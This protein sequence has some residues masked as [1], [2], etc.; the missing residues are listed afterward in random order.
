[1]SLNRVCGE[2]DPEPQD[3]AEVEARIALLERSQDTQAL[4]AARVEHATMLRDHDRLD[5][6]VAAFTEVM[7]T[8][9]AVLGRGHPIMVSAGYRLAYVHQKAGRL[10]LALATA[11][12]SLAQADRSL[13][14]AHEVTLLTAASLLSLLLADDRLEEHHALLEDRLADIIEGLGFANPLVRELAV[15]AP[16]ST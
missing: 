9:A 14:R 11:R 12:E 1:M 7:E 10:G 8:G 3:L 2:S 5:E 4:F 15:N 13:G 16:D 6:A